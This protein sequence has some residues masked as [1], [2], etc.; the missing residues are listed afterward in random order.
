MVDMAEWPDLLT[1]TYDVV[2]A[3]VALLE[4]PLLDRP[5]PCTEWA[6]R[7]LLAHTLG[8]ME[9]FAS[10]I[11]AP[12]GVAPD[13]ARPVERF[14]AAA[15]RSVAAW[16]SVTDPAATVTLPFATLPAGIVAGMNQLD[17]LV[18][19]WDLAAALGIGFAMPEDL[20]AVAMATAEVRCRQEPRSPVWGPE[21]PAR[22]DSSQE[23]LL[24]ITG[25]DTAPWPGAIWVAGS[26]VT[27]KPTSGDGG[28]ASG[29]EIWEREGS[30][31]P[32]HVHADHDELWY[33]LEG[34]FTFSLG[35]REFEAGAGQVVV[36]P[37]GVP[38]AFRAETPQSRLLDVHMPG[39][40]ERFFVQAGRPATDLVPPPREEA[41]GAPELRAMIESF[42]AAVVGP[43]L[44]H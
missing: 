43:P 18:H 31:P 20:A 40:F 41:D 12:P 27:V 35:D 8:T 42:G 44:G 13:V 4:E 11:G 5:T 26:L 33:V 15:A 39:G 28:T 24:A 38:H 9:G 36:G 6:I 37:R 21:V 7:D 22:G 19:G 25:R 17:V 14:D 32:R 34:R 29:V 10:A 30:G 1:R 2:R 16:R 3:P 23:R